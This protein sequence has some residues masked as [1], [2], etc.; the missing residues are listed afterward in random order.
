MT[1]T[2][3]QRSTGSVTKAEDH[4]SHI[5]KVTEIIGCSNES[6]EDAIQTAVTEFSKSVRHVTGVEVLKV[7]CP[8]KDGQIQEYRVDL[9]IAFGV[10]RPDMG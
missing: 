1:Q 4:V 10:E 7:S 2:Q 5:A 9:K 6:I 8:V 3:T